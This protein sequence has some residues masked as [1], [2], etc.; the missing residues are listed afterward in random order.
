MQYILIKYI[1]TTIYPFVICFLRHLNNPIMLMQL[2]I[3][4][5]YL[6]V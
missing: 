3:C 2:S 5:T 4:Q 6:F 1:V